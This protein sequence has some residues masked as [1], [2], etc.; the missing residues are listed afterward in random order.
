MTGSLTMNNGMALNRDLL[1]RSPLIRVTGEGGANLVTEQVDYTA[2]LNLVG[3]CAGQGALDAGDLSQ[4]PIPVHC[5]G[6]MKQ[7]DCQPDPKVLAQLAGRL[8]GSA[9]DIP[10]ALEKSFK[11]DP[12]GA[13]QGI[14]QILQQQKQ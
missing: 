14:F 13:I 5:R 7:P 6:T 11:E 3:S 8:F 12:A 1:A 10:G 9:K 2:T 4:Y